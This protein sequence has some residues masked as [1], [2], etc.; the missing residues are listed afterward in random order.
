MKKSNLLRGALIL[1]VGGV[2][3][4]IFS[5]VYRILLTRILG[6]EGIGLYQLIFPIYSLCVVIATAGL[7]LAISKVIS[8]NKGSEKRVLKKCFAL[9]FGISLVLSFIL[10]V[11]AKGLSAVQGQKQ[12]YVCY[13]ILA[14]SIILIGVSSVLRGYFQGKHNF[15]PSAVSNI[16]EQF[17]KLCVGLI[18]SLSLLFIGLLAA[19]IGA[20]IGIVVSELVSVFILLIFIKKENIKSD[21]KIDVS[22]KDIIKDVV[23]ITLTNIIIPIAGFVDSILVVNLL[24]FSFSNEMCVFLYGLESGAVS[25]LISLP[26]IFS[27]SIASVI[28]PSITHEK[29]NFNR[30][31]KLGCALKLI[32]IITIPCV[33]CF[34]LIPHRLV[35]FL[36]SNRLNAFGVDGLKIASRLLVW[37]GFGVVFFSINQLYSTCLQ[38]VEERFVGI[39]N[40]AIGMLVKFIIE[41][42]FMPNKYLNIYIL[43]IA[44]SIGYILTMILNHAEI[45]HRFKIKINYWFTAKVVL[46]NC[47][48]VLSLICVMAISKTA[49]NTLLSVIVAASV[50]LVSL[51]RLKIFNRRDKSM[52]KYKV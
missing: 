49:T 7:P 12:L 37:S 19:I 22:I 30:N 32:L 42:V 20:V 27:F 35:D 50:Y 21:S 28:M 46:A 34:T 15:T 10:F 18:L 16:L 33:V 17:V 38:A 14:P 41:I 29:N 44:N 8:K 13:M 36:Y 3:A 39:R 6:G 43:A 11:F 48:M 51:W 9:T 24:S 40:L 23:P 5:A 31:R 26:T 52:L 47:M 2:L 1:S 25:S 45:K 4:K